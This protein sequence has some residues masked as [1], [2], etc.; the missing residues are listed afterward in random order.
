MTQKHFRIAAVKTLGN[1]SPVAQ[2]ADELIDRGLHPHPCANTSIVEICRLLHGRTNAVALAD[3]LKLPFWLG[4]AIWTPQFIDLTE[5]GPNRFVRGSGIRLLKQ[6][7]DNFPESLGRIL[8]LF[9]AHIGVGLDERT[10]M[11]EPFRRKLALNPLKFGVKE[12][13]AP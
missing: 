6:F 2:R 1:L 13:V 12:M 7:P 8:Y 3:C 4:G 10:G 11:S 9:R 5:K